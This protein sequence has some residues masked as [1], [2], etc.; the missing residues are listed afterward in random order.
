MLPA[1][2]A[3]PALVT[4]AWLPAICAVL[5]RIEFEVGEGNT[6][7]IQL[8]FVPMLV[9]LPPG[10]V[11]LAVLA[12]HLPRD[13]ARVVRGARAARSALLLPVADCSFVLAPALV[14]VVAGRPDG[15]LGDA[16]ACVA[17]ARRADGRPTSRSRALRMRVGLGIDPRAGAARLRVGLPRRR[18]ASRRSASSP[19]WRATRTRRCSPPC[20]R[21]P[22]LLAVFA[23]ERR[24]RIEN[25]LALQ[26][27]A[28]EGRERLQTIVQNSSDLHPDRRPR[29]DAARCSPA[30]SRRSSAPTGRRPQGAPLLDR[31][32]PRGRGAGA[33]VPAVAWPRSR[34]ASRTRPSGGCATPTARY[35]HVA[36]VATNLL[37]DPRVGGIV[38][39]VRDVEARKA[40]EEQLRH[41]AFHDALTGLANRALFYDRIEHA[42]DRG[43]RAD[44]QV[45]VLFVDLDDFK[46][47]NDTR[48]HADGDA[49]LQSRSRAG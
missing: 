3:A 4:A 31:V 15:R 6:R 13:A 1:R 36:A 27:V 24:G 46:A 45:G 8:A 34:P 18:C 9:L 49:L 35:R 2:T 19:R 23:R 40:F 47:V 32:H 42:L 22:A 7:P 26:R 38:L 11:P 25:A 33:R 16:L 21:W 44:A 10:V 12:A 41:R 29:R 39:T 17:R 14:I 5:V 43:A 28:Q 37:D 48:G 30:P 20:C